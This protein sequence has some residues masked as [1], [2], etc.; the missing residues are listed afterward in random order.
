MPINIYNYVVFLTA[1]RRLLMKIYKIFIGLLYG[2]IGILI[3][4]CLG[5]LIYG[6]MNPKNLDDATARLATY[7]PYAPTIETLSSDTV[8]DAEH[9][10]QFVNYM[11]NSMG[12]LTLVNTGETTINDTKYY[13][14]STDD[15]S[16]TFYVSQST[17]AIYYYEG[18]NLVALSDVPITQFEKIDSAN[19][20]LGESLYKD[21][22]CLNL[23]GFSHDM[24]YQTALNLVLQKAGID[25]DIA[26]YSEKV[27]ST[28]R[29]NSTNGSA[30]EYDNIEITADMGNYILREMPVRLNLKFD[31]TIAGGEEEITKEDL[32]SRKL[33]EVRL[34]FRDTDENIVN[35]K[36]EESLKDEIIKVLG[37]PSYKF[38]SE[39]RHYYQW[40]YGTDT[41]EL[42]YYQYTVSTNGDNVEYWAFD[43]IAIKHGS[44]TANQE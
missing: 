9:A 21:G 33:V 26:D 39:G 6:T 24:T 19:Y 30:G 31:A 38:N 28:T 34:R 43:Y 5:L 41:L 15:G 18:S 17:G 37:E 1:Q 27:Y 16:Q 11:V 10:L 12:Q 29:Y 4:G 42:S 44:G 14:V 40:T 23:L 35:Y 25:K 32:L 20:I 13:V 7:S 8:I 3:I 2:V 36:G 22:D